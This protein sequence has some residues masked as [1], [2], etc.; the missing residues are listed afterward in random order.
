MFHVSS[1]AN[2]ASIAAHGLDWTRMGAAPG[3][4]GSRRPE[5]DGVFLC[6]SDSD[7]AFFLRLNNTGTAV[8]VWSVDGV[9]ESALVDGPHGWSFVPE[10]IEPSRLRL[11][12]AAV[13]PA[14]RSPDQL[15]DDAAPRAYRSSLTITFDDGRVLSGV[16]AIEYARG[17]RT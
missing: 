3:I 12:R 7:V 11:V 9:D 2:R 4:A 5:L 6:G 8:D 13:P 16:D 17:C 14:D 15:P 1:V 10:P